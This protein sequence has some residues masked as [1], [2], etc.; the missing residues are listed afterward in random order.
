MSRLDKLKEQHP[1]LN[2]SLIDIIT[3][4]DP[5]G[6]YKYT[7]FLIK[8]FKRDNQYYSPK[9]DELKGYLGVSLFGSNEIEVLNEF[10]RH[11][12]ANRIKE[13][14]ISKYK[15]FLELN[16][17]VKIA[18][19]IEKQKEV[20]KH[21]LKLHEDDTWLILTPLSFDASK[22]YGSNTKWCVTQ[23]KYWES[24]LSTHRLIYCINKET[25]IK[26]AFSREFSTEKFQAWD[27][28]DKEVSPMFIDIPDEIFLLIRKELQKNLRT[29]D[30][31]RGKEPLKSFRISDFVGDT[32]DTT[33]MEG[34]VDR[35]R[36]LMGISG[37]DNSD[38]PI[39]GIRP[40]D[41]PDDNFN[42]VVRRRITQ[43]PQVNIPGLGDYLSNSDVLGL[44]LEPE[45][46]NEIAVN[47]NPPS[48]SSYLAYAD[49]YQDQQTEQQ[50][51]EIDVRRR[52]T[53]NP[54]NIDVSDYMTYFSGSS[55][56]Y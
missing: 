28:K 45:V 8:N 37:T 6:T 51:E 24:Y 25:N 36:R 22:V 11:S 17:Q 44:N 38:N 26:T 15:N 12:R 53:D 19:D 2:I 32:V 46:T 33:N 54:R 42:P 39:I 43:F 55:I 48:L 13:K 49:P 4:L 40:A 23:E 35:L 14:D 16:E 52:I 5:T 9:L 7:E 27:Q 56:N 21:I 29:I 47:H 3:S 20:E 50:S 10:E 41:T 30:L 34:V 1:D 18:E 31:I